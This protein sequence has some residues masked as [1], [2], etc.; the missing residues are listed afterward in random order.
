MESRDRI[1]FMFCDSSGLVLQSV[2]GMKVVRRIGLNDNLCKENEGPFRQSL[3]ILRRTHKQ[4][5]M[6]QDL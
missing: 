5:V 4:A 2:K 1:Q 3:G 6:K